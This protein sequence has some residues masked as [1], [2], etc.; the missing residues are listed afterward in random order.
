MVVYKL[1]YNN[2]NYYFLYPVGCFTA[3]PRLIA[4]LWGWTKRE[5]KWRGEGNG[6][7]V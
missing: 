2:N 4:G 1:D 5:W 3:V 7:E 6:R